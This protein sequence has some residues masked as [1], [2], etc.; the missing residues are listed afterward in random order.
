[1]GLCLGTFFPWVLDR[2]KES[3]SP[4][5]PWAWGVNGIFSVAAPIPSVGISMT[6]GIGALLL[7]A[8]PVYLVATALLP[9]AL[10]EARRTEDLTSGP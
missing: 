10:A 3:S 8:L 7:A 1:L 9:P 5:I 6:F 4:L 2:L